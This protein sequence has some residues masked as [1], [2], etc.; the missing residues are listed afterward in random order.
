VEI[1][2]TAK[3]IIAVVEIRFI[4]FCFGLQNRVKSYIF[5]FKY[6][7]KIIIPLLTMSMKIKKS[8]RSITITFVFQI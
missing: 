8:I 7:M 2:A 3:S 4:I 5:I 1:K 6:E